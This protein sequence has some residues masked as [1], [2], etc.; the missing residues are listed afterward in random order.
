MAVYEYRQ[1]GVFIW[2]LISLSETRRIVSPP[3][4]VL[5]EQPETVF[6]AAAEAVFS[7]DGYELDAQLPLCCVCVVFVSVGREIPPRR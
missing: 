3:N 1:F 7:E 2:A 6:G 5:T 4:Q